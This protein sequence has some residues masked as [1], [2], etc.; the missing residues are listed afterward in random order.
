[1]KK[2]FTNSLSIVFLAVIV[3]APTYLA[4]AQATAPT[5]TT[6]A[7]APTNTT[8]APRPTNTTTVPPRPTSATGGEINIPNPFGRSGGSLTEL[9]ETIVNSII[10]PI[11]G[12]L[13]VLAFVYSGFL[14]VT[15]QGNPGKIEEAN[16]ALLYSAI[17][18]A[19]L[20]GS[21]VIANVI[22]GTID[23]LKS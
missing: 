2:I 16:R 4:L 13:A 10:L 6:T 3:F 1:M 11:G 8:T 14:Y 7:P 17:G 18:T 9:F 19:V 22:G 23:Q 5:N 15:A 20:L 12:V 21:W